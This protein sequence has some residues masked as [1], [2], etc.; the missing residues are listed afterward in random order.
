MKR[1]LLSIIIIAL[2]VLTYIASTSNAVPVETRKAFTFDYT[3]KSFSK[4]GS[5][6]FLLAF[7][8]PKF[9]HS[10]YNFL[11]GL[12]LYSKIQTSFQADMEEMLIAK[13]FNI[14][15]TFATYDE[16]VFNDKKDVQLLFSV[17]IVPSI[18]NISGGWVKGQNSSNQTIWAYSGVVTL[19]GKITISG[20]EPL[21][22]EKVF[23]KS[24]TIPNVEYIQLDSKGYYVDMMNAAKTLYNPMGEAYLQIYDNIIDKINAQFDPQE[25]LTLKKEIKELKAKKGY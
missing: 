16:M 2:A 23:V 22:N 14:K 15:G 4:A 3:P 1:T 6:N 13:G 5:A 24:V 11:G 18:T 20:V 19:G 10:N 9:K 7:T 21:T 17:E 25:M 8:T 12:D